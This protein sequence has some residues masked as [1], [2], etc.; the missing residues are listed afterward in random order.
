MMNK[1]AK[2]G[3]T[4]HA[5][6]ELIKKSFTRIVVYVLV[7]AF[8]AG[9]IGALTIVL[10]R[11]EK[12]YQAIIEYNYEG[13]ESGLDPWGR[14]LDVTKI[15]SDAI[16]TKALVENEYSE[17]RRAKLKNGIINNIAIAG[18]VPEDI[19]KKIL[20]IKEIATKTPTQLNELTGLSYF[21]TS[22]V[23]SLKN[24][25]KLG[26]SG[27][28]C[29][30][31]LNSIVD[32]YILAFK[33]QYG[34]NNA[35]GTLI[36]EEVN[37]NG[38]DY[39]ELHSLYADQV[40]SVMAYLDDMISRSASFRTTATKLSFEDMKARV[41]SIR[42]YD[43]YKLEIYIYGKGV[44]RAD[45]TIDAVTFIDEKINDIARSIAATEASITAT[46]NAI[47][48][49]EFVY[50]TT[51]TENNTT[52]SVL[53]NGAA[54]EKLY[55]N[56]RIYQSQLVSLNSTKALWETR[57]AKI[58]SAASMSEPEKAASIATAE[59]LLDR[60][61]SKITEEIGY[62]NEAVDEYIESE[63]MKNSII[64]TVSAVEA[65]RDDNAIKILILAE[66]IVMFAAAVT[67]M[68]VTS[69]KEKKR[70]AIIENAEVKE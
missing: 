42:D 40:D 45:S 1:T 30:N 70:A 61:N 29:I 31:I 38:Y 60:I 27:K 66:L 23:I 16:V 3:L 64:K 21:S 6:W 36:G 41:K 63:V 15:R 46:N 53:A 67:A 43:L 39:L 25:K 2:D 65:P 47:A 14:K 44:S 7:A 49:F 52:T 54:Y 11:D 59:S 24:D 4:F 62:I 22:Y 10:V 48:N 68:C 13:V 58:N 56:L 19:M 8:V 57:K 37:R 26:L 20:I 51:T 18:V 32:N 35:L 9:A 12:V 5:L 28:E 50:N 17:E 34:F 33:Q 69:A 55:D